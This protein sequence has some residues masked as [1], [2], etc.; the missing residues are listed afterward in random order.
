MSAST[1]R[2]TPSGGPLCKSRISRPTLA[3]VFG[4][5]FSQALM[6]ALREYDLPEAMECDND[7]VDVSNERVIQC[8]SVKGRRRRQEASEVS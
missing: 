3:S 2:R 7:V 6:L 5:K 1:T 4:G 8:I